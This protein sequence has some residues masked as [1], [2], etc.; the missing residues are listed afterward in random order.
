M[1]IIYST[2]AT[3]QAAQAMAKKLLEH[4]AAACVLLMPAQSLYRWKGAVEQGREYLMMVKTTEHKEQ[5]V[6]DIL[7]AY[8]PYEV[9][10]II[11]CSGTAAG[12][13]QEFLEQE[14]K[15]P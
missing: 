11:S 1:K 5:E 13:Y 3:E 15:I 7:A 10:C 14:T 6:Q 4:H 2:F 8:H 12:P 9:P